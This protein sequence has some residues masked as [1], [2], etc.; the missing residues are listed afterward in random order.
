MK[1]VFRL[2]INIILTLIALAVADVIALIFCLA[3]GS[4]WGLL[5]IIIG[6]IAAIAVSITYT[7]MKH[8]DDE[9]FIKD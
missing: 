5:V 7:V 6:D 4:L 9:I 1:L 2:A 3:S 8:R